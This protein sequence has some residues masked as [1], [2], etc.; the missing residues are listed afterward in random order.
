MTTIISRRLAPLFVAA[1][2]VSV[3]GD[4]SFAQYDCHTCLVA[5]T[6]PNPSLCQPDTCPGCYTW[7][8]VNYC[9]SCITSITLRSKD[10]IKF[11]M[12]C[13][14]VQR[15]VI[16]TW[17]QTLSPDSLFMPVPGDPCLAGISDTDMRHRTLQITTCGLASGDLMDLQ[18]G[19]V[20]PPCFN[21]EHDI[22]IP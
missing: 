22:V 19:P 13:C 5:T 21:N 4:V 7:D 3:V 1:F 14:A 12:C 18:W 15:L 20:D 9:N 17:N 6:D 2:L 8:L 10:G 11:H 16:Q